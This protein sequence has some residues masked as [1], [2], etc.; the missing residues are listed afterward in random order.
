MSLLPRFVESEPAEPRVLDVTG[1]DAA[2]AFDALS[3]E[4][5]R[6]ILATIYE[7]PATP[8]EV[9]EAVGTTLQNVHYHLDRLE[10]AGLVEDAGVGYSEK[11]NEMTIYAP[12]SEAVLLF[13]GHE[14]Q[15]S[16]LQDV[17]ARVL[18]LYI[19]LGLTSLFVAFLTREPR[20]E[21]RSFARS[22]D[23]AA[24]GGGAAT[25]PG[26]VDL[27]SSAVDAATSLDPALTFFLGGCVVI[28]A[29]GVWWYA[30][31]VRGVRA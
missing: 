19:L 10:A 14:H 15:R 12:A 16:R 17:L 8:T 27:T 31:E 26:S 5:A 9:R 11:G 1:D 3:S 20:G 29:L 21:I 13:A 2:E 4:T 30:R 18:G 28:A 24:G 7:E 25:E 22:K 23:S 6:H